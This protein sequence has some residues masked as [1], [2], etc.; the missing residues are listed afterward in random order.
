LEYGTNT[1]EMHRDAI[2]PGQRVIIVD[3]LLATGG[4]MQATIELVKELKGEIVG[5]GFA[6]ELDFLKGRQKLTG[7][8]IFSLLNYSE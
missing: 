5:L 2:R 6:V 8:D 7:H 1:L 3:D 4:T